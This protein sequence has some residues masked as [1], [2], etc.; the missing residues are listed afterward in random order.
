MKYG[1]GRCSGQPIESGLIGAAMA[2]FDLYWRAWRKFV[3]RR[4]QKR[5]D[6]IAGAGSAAPL[7]VVAAPPP[8]AP[9]PPP[10]AARA[11][12]FDVAPAAAAPPPPPRAAPPRAA[13]PR[14][15]APPPPPAAGRGAAAGRAP[16][17]A[18]LR[19]AGAGGAR[20]RL[21]SLL[22]PPTRA[23]VVEFHARSGPRRSAPAVAVDA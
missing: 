10:A 20:C 5:Q 16:L 1:A 9:A 3:R 8:A 6:A 4:R 22:A 19:R 11:V 21:S 12:T 14:A 2:S 23:L 17:D 15:A 18:V 13:A 7:P